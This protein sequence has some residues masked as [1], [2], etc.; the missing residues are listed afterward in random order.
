MQRIRILCSFLLIQCV[1]SE[2]IAIVPPEGNNES[3]VDDRENEIIKFWVNP[4]TGSISTEE[5]PIELLPCL[6]EATSS[7]TATVA[8]RPTK[9][10]KPTTPKTKPPSPSPTTTKPIEPTSS[11]TS[12]ITEQI[13]CPGEF[14]NFEDKSDGTIEVNFKYAVETS[15]II[16]DLSNELPR[17]EESLLQKLAEKLLNHC[18]TESDIR[19]SFTFGTDVSRY[20]RRNLKRRRRLET[21]GLCSRPDDKL[22]GEGKLITILN[23]PRQKSFSFIY[24]VLS[25]HVICLLKKRKNHATPNLIPQTTVLLFKVE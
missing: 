23:S 15:S 4:C 2:F 10:T 7:P 3:V 6:K 14:F 20:R 9:P 11:P 13:T 8:I 24:S 18:M 21:L 17:L 22:L 1:R 12:T 5:K 16:T 19:R 25:T